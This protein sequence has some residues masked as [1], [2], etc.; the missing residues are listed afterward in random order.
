M[1]V[2]SIDEIKQYFPHT[3][4]DRFDRLE[5][6]IANAEETKLVKVVGFPLYEKLC[7]LYD[8][9]G[10][11]IENE[12]YARLLKNV[13]RPIVQ[14]GMFEA[15]PLLNVTINS[16]GGMTVT[17][18]DNVVAASKD[19]YNALSEATLRQ[20]WESIDYLLEFLERNSGKFLDSENKELWKQSEWY[21]QQTGLLI[22]TAT[23]FENAGVYLE[24][25]RRKFIQLYISVINILE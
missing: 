24:N 7:E 3:T 18:N 25:K 12:D 8:K 13:Q 20:A 1:L 6:F 10:A 16:S 4:L 9:S 11:N 17:T 19:R 15:F 23:E 14:F 22:F 2:K 21:W 5:S